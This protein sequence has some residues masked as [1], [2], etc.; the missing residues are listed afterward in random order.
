MDDT[1]V[2][3][4]V[5]DDAGTDSSSSADARPVTLT[6]LSSTEWAVS[7]GLV[8]FSVNPTSFDITKLHTS[9]N[10]VTTNWMDA[11]SPSPFGHAVQFYNLYS[12]DN[13]SGVRGTSVAGYRLQDGYLDIWVDKPN[14]AGIDPLGVENHWVIRDG[15][16]TIH[17]YQILRHTA[18]DAATTF[19]AATVNFFPSANA[20]SRV[21]GSSYLYMKNTGPNNMTAM[22]ETFPADSF[23]QS[24]LAGEPGRQVQ[25]ETV[26]YTSTRLG[27]LVCRV[28]SSRNTIT[29]PTPNLMSRMALSAR[30]TRSGGWCRVRKHSTAVRPSSI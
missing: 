29:R 10:G 14:I 21:D 24:L 16:P 26:D 11:S 1:V 17:F 30:R 23:T 28:N 20:I 8:S 6:Q 9:I 4:P 7:N 22:P 13:P 18:A 5:S 3:A 27:A 25:A 15:D 2:S 12:Y 19:G